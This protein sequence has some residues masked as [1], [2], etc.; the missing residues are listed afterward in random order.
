M[1]TQYNEETI[2]TLEWKEHI[3]K[4]PGMYIGKLGDGSLRDDGIYVLLKE[5]IDNAVDE[6]IMGFGK[7]IEVEVEGNKVRVR[8]YGRGIPLGKL[9]DV[10]SKMNT[11]A[12]YDSKV[13]KKTVGLNGI[14]IKAVNALSSSFI[15]RSFRDGKCKEVIFS[16]GLLLQE[17]LFDS[18]ELT[19]TEVIFVPDHEIFG[20]FSFQPEYVE[21]MVKNYV[22]LNRDLIIKYN[23][24]DYY[25]KN[26]L[27]D[28]LSE[29]LNTTPL[30]PIVY[31]RGEDIEIAFTHGDGYN[32]EY[33]TFVNGQHTSQ[34]G[35]HLVA[36]KEAFTET[37][38]KFYKKDFDASDIR[39]S[40]I[41]AISIRIEEPIFE[42]QTKSK[43]GSKDVRPG[44]PSIKNFI[45]DFVRVEL[46]NYLH[47]NPTVADCI[48][49]KILESEKER[50]AIQVIQ[51][52]TRELSKRA[53]I[54]NKKLRDCKIHFTDSH[55]L[56]SQ[57][58]IFITE[59][60]SASGSIT[61]VR[62]PETQAV[63]SLRGKPE[64]LFGKSKKFIYQNEELNL[65][66]NALGIED[67]I[68]NLRYNYIVIASD[69]DADGM[70]IRL[71][72]ISFFLQYFPEVVKNGHLYV[73][74]TPLFRV[75]NKFQTIYCYNEEEKL[76]A[77]DKLGKGVEITRFKGLGEISPEEFKIFIG[78]NMKLLPI[79][80][81][82]N[83]T[84]HNLLS[85]YMGNNTPERQLFV[86][87]NLQIIEE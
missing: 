20:N 30:Y 23:Y 14:G 64:N 81:S 18:N 84:I 34:G 71:L 87:N 85:F 50:K 19:G 33:F 55:E 40:L 74:Q 39:T 58:T 76:K 52:K 67:G 10:A 3:R 31:L 8:D 60:D 41:A 22:Y 69:A 78:E 5:I 25:S 37:I 66:I 86:I 6:F 44:G 80:L 27:A 72:L 57:S 56:S 13:F 70:H 61:K 45:S 24:V 15:L 68:D 21:E 62:N 36:F 65:L 79:T 42:S 16:K 26:G 1:W 47:K 83:D 17:Q 49:K 48:L 7:I 54:H 29:K 75:R 38:R 32:D 28:L 4:R 53:S 63:F 35:T 43:L 12:K 59:G 46:D 2:I 51:K 9:I 77:I 73:L 11:G 82:K